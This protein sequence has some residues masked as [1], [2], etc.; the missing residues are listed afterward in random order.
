MLPQC[1]A[2][3]RGLV[4]EIIVVDTGS[5]DRTREI[6]LAAGAKVYDF[7]WGN[8]FSQARNESLRH[9]TG[10]WVLVMDP[11]EVVASKGPD[12]VRRAILA[13]PEAAGLTAMVNSLVHE[14]DR[15]Q[16][17][18][19]IGLRLFRRAPGVL[20]EGAI[21]EQVA[22][23]ITRQGG[24][25]AASGLVLTH[26]GYLPSVRA[27]KGK[28]ARNMRLLQEQVAA[29]PQNIFAR[30]NLGTELMVAR[31]WEEALAEYNTAWEMALREPQRQVYFN[32][33]ARERARAAMWLGRWDEA[34][35]YSEEA[36]A[37]Y[38][39]YP[40][41]WLERGHTFQQQQDWAQVHECAGRCLAIAKVNPE[42]SSD[43]GARSWLPWH[44]N[45]VAYE[46][47]GDISQAIA[48]Y[49]RA[50]QANPAYPDSALRL[51]FLGSKTQDE[52]L[53]ERIE[54]ALQVSQMG[55]ELIA[56]AHY[57]AH[58][59]AR[60]GAWAERAP[61]NGAVALARGAAQ[62]VAGDTRAAVHA[63]ESTPL[64]PEQELDGA[65]LGSIVAWLEGRWQDAR[66]I[67]AALAERNA[68]TAAA[69]ERVTA[70]LAG[71]FPTAQPVTPDLL[72]TLGWLVDLGLYDL[73]QTVLGLFANTP[74]PVW[75]VPVGKV[76]FVK[77]FRQPAFDFLSSVGLEALDSEALE[78][79][80]QFAEEQGLADEA[81]VF[82]RRAAG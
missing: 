13:H 11:D 46:Q 60:A 6:A 63:L 72:V 73:F 78:M 59:F 30:F 61:L 49:E 52:A 70:F 45:G 39:D 80:A 47:E 20:Y 44:L 34:L 19:S 27:S 28:E 2:S 41:L 16:Q 5:V 22:P 81:A 8:D 32:K 71:G 18:G 38:P 82:R 53:L 15:T 21:H 24:R 55:L 23:A 17:G 9:A 33:L 40:D 37:R 57:Q 58:R 26:Y 10:D 48:C 74:P 14:L 76:L 43:P 50:I 31:R 25:L 51:A 77:G 75:R 54:A 67:A 56:Q 64:T 7:P 66:A 4:D 65:Y 36:I 35:R 3:V 68:E 69:L 12:A 62:L 1:L 42:Y 29:D 79:L